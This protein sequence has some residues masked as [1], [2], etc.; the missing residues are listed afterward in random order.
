MDGGPRGVRR[1]HAV[2]ASGAPDCKGASQTAM[3]RSLAGAEATID[4]RGESLS[5]LSSSPGVGTP[6]TAGAA[7][8]RPKRVGV[9]RAEGVRAAKTPRRLLIQTWT[10]DVVVLATRSGSP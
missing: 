9:G 6:R 2:F 8:C 5:V 3:R 1:G 10:P 4:G 7:R